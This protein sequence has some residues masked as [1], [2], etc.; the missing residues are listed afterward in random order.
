[1]A[2]R[3]DDVTVTSTLRCPEDAIT[4]QTRAT[5]L[6]QET[7]RFPIPWSSLR[8]FDAYQ[9]ALTGTANTDDLA[10][11]GG[12]FGT[13][14]P[15]VQAGSAA[16]ASITRYA[17]FQVIV[18][19]CYVAGQAFALVF[20]AG[21]KTTVADTSATLDVECYRA[22]KISGISADLCTTAAQ[23][24]NSLVFADK[25]FTITPGTLLPGDILDCRITIAA[26][27]AATGAAVTPTIAGMDISC[28]IKG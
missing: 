21:M 2:S 8:I 28:A 7:A 11:I 1:M 13:A 5:I 24:I 14:P 10:L 17:R 18:P 9:T 22:D 4:A 26:V 3:F 23:S 12:T 19:E 27:D 20:S 15:M 16:I 25:S 6:K